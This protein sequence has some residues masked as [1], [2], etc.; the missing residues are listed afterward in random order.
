MALNSILT[1][2]FNRFH[3]Y[4]KLAGSG[5]ILLEHILVLLGG[6]RVFGLF[7]FLERLFFRKAVAAVVKLNVWVY[8]EVSSRARDAFPV[9]TF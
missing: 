1:A 6:F 4:V 8:L 2:E 3:L 9:W 7:D 5:L